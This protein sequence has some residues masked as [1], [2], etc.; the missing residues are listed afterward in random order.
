MTTPSIER[1]K[2]HRDRIRGCYTYE[3]FH[4]AQVE[5]VELLIN[6]LEKEQEELLSYARDLLQAETKAIERDVRGN[7]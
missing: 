7:P 4:E 3:A 6:L 5:F 2:R 1:L